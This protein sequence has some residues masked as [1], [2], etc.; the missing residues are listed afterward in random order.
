MSE[1]LKDQRDQVLFPLIAKLEFQLDHLEIAARVLKKGQ[2]ALL[3]HPRYAELKQYITQQMAGREDDL[4]KF[5]GANLIFIWDMLNG[6]DPLACRVAWLKKICVLRPDRMG[7]SAEDFQV[8]SRGFT[9]LFPDLNELLDLYSCQVLQDDF[10]SLNLCQKKS[11]MLWVTSV[12]WN[13]YG[14]RPDFLRIYPAF[15]KLFKE[16]LGRQDLEMALFI[17]HPLATVWMVNSQTQDQFRRFSEDVSQKL[18]RHVLEKTVSGEGLPPVTRKLV[19]G[20][21]LKIAFVMN[22][23]VENSPLR[24]LRD[25][26]KSLKDVAVH[27]NFKLVV[28]DVGQ[29]EKS[30]SDQSTIQSIRDL[31]IPCVCIQEMIPDAN[32]GLYYSVAQKLKILRKKIVD[33]GV[34]VLVL[35]T[36]GHIDDYLLATRTAPVQI[37]WSH[38]NYVYDV[39]GIDARITH[40][41]VEEGTVF[42]RLSY[43]GH[44]FF[45]FQQTFTRERYAP[46]VGPEVVRA[47]RARFPREALLLGSIGRS[48]KVESESYMNAVA[49]IMTECP[50]TVYVAVGAGNYGA[51]REGLMMR[52]I[53]GERVFLEGYQN[54]HPYGYMLDLFL[55]TFPLQNGESFGEF[56]AKQ[57]VFVRI[58]P[59]VLD[60]MD[61]KSTDKSVSLAPDDFFRMYAYSQQ[62]YIRVACYLIRSVLKNPDRRRQLVFE[63]G[64]YSYVQRQIH[65]PERVAQSFIAILREILSRQDVTKE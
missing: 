59:L 43:E 39:P 51:F 42:K 17:H 47:L 40:G 29:I 3:P 22:R 16:S 20:Q 25:L 65:S 12:F 23:L 13:I 37:F 60:T 34:D 28:Y 36:E 6:V 31:E 14:P 55:D 41:G 15:L 35:S 7:F 11:L 54:P 56:V 61:A 1:S 30:P 53:L 27:E 21:D 50:D 2:P 63:T 45:G 26:L 62:D 52:G 9:A 4:Q 38:G 32:E 46:D 18:S 33:D 10:W 44:D 64:E 5:V 19:P 8:F 24:V 49:Q 58:H 57:G 48:I